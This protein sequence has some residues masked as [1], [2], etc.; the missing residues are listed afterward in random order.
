VKQVGSEYEVT[1][2][3][4]AHQFEADPIGNETEV[5]LDTWFQVVVF[6]DSEQELLA[7]TPL[8]QAQHRLHGGSQRLTVRV[9]QKPGA[10]GV[11]PYHLMIDKVPQDNVRVLS[12]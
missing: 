9:P 8:Y 2:D 4:D 6:P 1:M 10:A 12:H 5:P 7:Q 11:D 3:I